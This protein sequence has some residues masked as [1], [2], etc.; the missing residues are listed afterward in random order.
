MRPEGGM[1]NRL[2][3]ACEPH[4]LAPRHLQIGTS[5][6]VSMPEERLYLLDTFAFIFSVSAA[7]IRETSPL[8]TEACHG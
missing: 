4:R 1:K 7:R 8:S 6:T 2:H 5:H 3:L